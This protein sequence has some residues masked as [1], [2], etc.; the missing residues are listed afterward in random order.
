MSCLLYLYISGPTNVETESGKPNHSLYICSVNK[1]MNEIIFLPH[2]LLTE[3]VVKTLTST[4]KGANKLDSLKKIDFKYE[5]CHFIRSQPWL[6]S[7][8]A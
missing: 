1:W 8:T 3:L 2:F 4:F 7:I 6:E 5:L